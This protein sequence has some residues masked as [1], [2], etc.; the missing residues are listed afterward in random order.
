[1]GQADASTRVNSITHDSPLPMCGRF[2]ISLTLSEQRRLLQATGADADWT[3]SWNVCPTTQIPVMLGDDSGRRL[4]LMRW[5]WNPTS[6]KG[7]LLINA[8][9]EEAHGKPTF[10]EPLDR[11]RCLIPATAF[12]EWK[13]AVSKGERP[14]PF[15]FA[16]REEPLFTIG[17]LWE[18]I[19]TS[20][21]ARRGQVIL[22]TVPANPLVAD[23]HDRMPLVIEP[24]DRDRWLSPSVGTSTARSLIVTSDAAL[25]TSHRISNAISDVHRT[26]SSVADP[27]ESR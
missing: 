2:S 1:M 17:A 24:L 14:L 23:V 20:D 5:G 22:L 25:W 4:G 19:T 27:I 12:Y 11:R 6:I 15:S 18:T 9:A 7:R 21:G 13:P 16:R 3:P 8:R 26:D 10:R